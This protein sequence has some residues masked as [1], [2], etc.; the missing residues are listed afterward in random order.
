[1]DVT[2]LYHCAVTV[3]I[4][5]V[6]NTL[7]ILYSTTVTK[8]YFHAF[9]VFVLKPRHRLQ[10]A[11][12]RARRCGWCATLGGWWLSVL[13]GWG[14]AYQITP[15]SSLC[16]RRYRDPFVNR[17]NKK[18]VRRAVIR[19]GYAS[20]LTKL[21]KN[22]VSPCFTKR[23]VFSLECTYMYSTVQCGTRYGMCASVHPS[24]YPRQRL[25]HRHRHRHLRLCVCLSARVA[26][27]T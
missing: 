13:V 22:N 18:C 10:M 27:P 8:L 15:I 7:P 1:M 12:R 11:S 16:C 21:E 25:R 4:R 14:G 5:I 17:A 6:V 23:R 9:F 20:T 3:E 24:A 19:I 26:N 2:D